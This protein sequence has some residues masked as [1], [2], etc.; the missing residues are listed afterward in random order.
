MKFWYQTNIG[1]Q[2]F[3]LSPLSALVRRLTDKRRRQR[4]Q[5]AY[6]APVVVVGNLTV[7][8]TGKT[9][10]IIWLVTAL[11]QQGIRV[12]VVSRG[13]GATQKVNY[14]VSLTAQSSVTQVGDEPKLIQLRT[15]CQVVVDPDRNRAVRHLLQQHEVDVVISDDGMQHYGM[16]RDLELLMVD[17][18]RLFGNQK[19]LPAGPLRE[20]M[21]R[22]ASVDF[23]VTK[24]QP[25]RELILPEA[26][27]LSYAANLTFTPPTNAEGKS[28]TEKTINLTSAIGN[29]DSFVASVEALGFQI[30]ERH[31]FNDH[32][33]IPESILND[34]KLPLVITEKDAVKINL[35]NY[36]NLYVLKLDFEL[37][38]AFKVNILSKIEALIYEKSSHHSSTL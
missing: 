35:E 1:W 19:L 17:A 14:P 6:Q 8:G 38:K 2:A 32:D 21:A 13:Y 3:C 9:P 15:G 10:M 4:N 31:R 20:S 23:I 29:F 7:G 24:G 34:S 26:L 11:Q 18:E 28:L 27:Q 37:P 5:T 25:S 22:L 30:A 12:G 33:F 16:H 36:P